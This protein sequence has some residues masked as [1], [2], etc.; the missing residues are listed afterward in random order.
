MTAELLLHGRDAPGRR[1]RPHRGGGSDRRAGPLAGR[2]EPQR[3]E[4]RPHAPRSQ[5]NASSEPESDLLLQALERGPD[6]QQLL[7][8]EC[9]VRLAHTVEHPICTPSTAGA[10]H[11][12]H[13]QPRA[14]SS[15]LSRSTPA[16]PA[17]ADPGSR[18]C[19]LAQPII[20]RSVCLLS[21]WFGARRTSAVQVDRSPVIRG[22][23]HP[24]EPARPRGPG[25]PGGRAVLP[26]PA[27]PVPTRI[28][29]PA[30]ARQ[31]RPWPSDVDRP[32]PATHTNSSLS[33]S[34]GRS[35]NG[36]RRGRAP[37]SGPG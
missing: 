34:S 37:K 31:L 6:Q 27:Q 1:E 3:R 15:T 28:A 25:L 20:G 17:P 33:G 11:D 2:A 8:A 10:P 18:R 36:R 7:L 4:P 29:S 12:P 30:Q 16:C 9:W 24:A 13:V 35:R 23:L 26:R 19:D 5:Q 32:E 14:S 22:T 21:S